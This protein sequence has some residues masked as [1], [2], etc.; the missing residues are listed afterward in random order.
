MALGDIRVTDAIMDAMKQHF[1]PRQIV[2]V[3]MSATYYGALGRMVVALGVDLDDDSVL[4]TERDW[5]KGR[6]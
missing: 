6:Q 1:S 2:D 4:Q 5:Q 3:A